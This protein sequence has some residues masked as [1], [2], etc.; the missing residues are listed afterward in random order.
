MKRFLA[1]LLSS[2]VF[3]T[4]LPFATMAAP[5]EG[6]DLSPSECVSE[7]ITRV[8]DTK[9]T[10]LTEDRKALLEA[11]ES[12]YLAVPEDPNKPMKALSEDDV[13][14]DPEA[15]KS[16]LIDIEKHNGKEYFAF[17][18]IDGKTH[19]TSY[20]RIKNSKDTNDTVYCLNMNLKNPSSGSSMIP[21]GKEADKLLYILRLGHPRGTN[22]SNPCRGYFYSSGGESRFHNYYITQL[23]VWIA[24]GDLKQSSVEHGTA[25]NGAPKDLPQKAARFYSSAQ[26]YGPRRVAPSINV[27]HARVEAVED[28][29]PSQLSTKAGGKEA[30]A[31]YLGAKNVVSNELQ[32]E[33]LQVKSFVIRVQNPPPGLR[34]LV[35]DN[36]TKRDRVY[37]W[38]KQTP[39]IYAWEALRFVFPNPGKS[40]EFT[41][42]I[43]GDYETW[44]AY[45]YTSS[46]GGSYQNMLKEDIVQGDKVISTDGSVFWTVK[47]TPPPPPPTTTEVKIN[48]IDA[49]TGRPLSGATIGIF[50]QN[51]QKVFEFTSRNS[52]VDITNRVNEGQSYYA[53]EIQAPSGYELDSSKHPFTVRHNDTIMV[54]IV[55]RKE[56][57][58]DTYKIK[59][60]KE[61]SRNA[62]KL[63]GAEFKLTGPVNKIK[64]TNPQGIVEFDKLYAGTY[65]ITETKAPNGYTLPANATQTVTVGPQT[66]NKTLTVNFKDDKKVPDTF[67]LTAL[68]VDATNQNPLMGAEFTLTGPNGQTQKGTSSAEGKVIF[69]NLTELGTYTIEETK[70]P[71][72]YSLAQ[73]PRQTVNVTDAK[74]PPVTTFKFENQPIVKPFELKALKVDATNQNP[75][76]GAEFT[77]TK[78]NGQ[79]MTATSNA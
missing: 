64:T 21:K 56:R 40:G 74:N 78:P 45:R 59:V 24:V 58:P 8:V 9:Y 2:V 54:E 17:A 35:R 44:K 62:S 16:K 41:Y 33:G 48:K 55:N 27:S 57:I 28:K 30:G 52:A 71:N 72:G 49:D 46:S 53:Q 32:D 60:I 39:H 67:E 13:I 69:S 65:T 73:N 26:K 66:P 19:N 5:M 47:E 1:V 15:P 77:L 11:Q 79:I 34:V 36:V 7:N 12:G 68:K 38:G 20:K 37:E 61:D 23:A 10:P 6:E 4:S 29:D 75:L 42:T 51:G 25:V 76:A 3:A 18:K 63:A 31:L 14:P 70:A 22:S 43:T 50:T